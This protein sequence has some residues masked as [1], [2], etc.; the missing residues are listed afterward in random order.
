M[1]EKDNPTLSAW[2]YFRF[3]V[4]APLLSAPPEKGLVGSTAMTPTVRPVIR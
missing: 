1:T 4:V 3:S 2:A